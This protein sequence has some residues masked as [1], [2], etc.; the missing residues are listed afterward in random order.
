MN[1]G[2]NKQPGPETS[3]VPQRQSLSLPSWL[4]GRTIAILMGLVSL[5][6]MVQT[7]HSSLGD[8]IH[9]LRDEM[10]GMRT[11]LRQ[12]LRGEIGGLRHDLSTLSMRI[13]RVRDE[14]RTDI[15]RLDERLRIVEID[16]AAIRTHLLGFDVRP[17][18]DKPQDEPS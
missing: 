9:R 13:E 17:P 11:E 12:E 6:V 2:D 1:S 10:H 8:D 3:R 18:D 4:D 5:A 7:S 14:L 15:Q 16:V